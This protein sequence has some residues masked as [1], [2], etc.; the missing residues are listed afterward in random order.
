MRACIDEMSFEAAHYTPV[1]GVP[2]LHGHTFTVSVCV[3]GDLGSDYMVIDFTKLREVVEGVIDKYRYSLIIP[4]NDLDLI[5]IQGPF[6]VKLALVEYPQ[7]TA[8]AISSS[9]CDELVAV[10]K[11]VGK[12]FRI[13]VK[14]V[15]GKN[16]YVECVCGT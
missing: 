9:I 13:S 10:F 14:V 15:E 7:A 8:E 11:S 6:R 5:N 2:Q 1:N 12:N 3:D 4:K 16:N